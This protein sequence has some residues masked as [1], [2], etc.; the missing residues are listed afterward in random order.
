MY[1]FDN[2]MKTFCVLGK[3]ASRIMFEIESRTFKK[4]MNNM[5]KSYKNIFFIFLLGSV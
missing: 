4:E 5:H 3:L 1:A 2:P